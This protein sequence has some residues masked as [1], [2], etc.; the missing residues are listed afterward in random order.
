MTI[1]EDQTADL[2]REFKSSKLPQFRFYP[3]LKTGQE[4]RAASFEIVYPKNGDIGEVREAVLEEIF[5]NY[6][7]DV[8]D[9]SEKVY[10]S[11]GGANSKDGKVTVCYMYE[12][13]SVDFTYK[14]LSTD[15]YLSE[16]VVFMAIDSPSASMTQD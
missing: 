8:K 10:Y 9:V 3:N 14:A 7:S 2:K 4:K 6:E 13:G 16:D 11:L 12:E 1:D 15:P 5:S